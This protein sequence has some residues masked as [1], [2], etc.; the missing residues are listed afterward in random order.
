MLT[1]TIKDLKMQLSN[2]NLLIE[3]G[4]ICFELLAQ[5]VETSK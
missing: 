1:I 2:F 3:K 5:K 4:A